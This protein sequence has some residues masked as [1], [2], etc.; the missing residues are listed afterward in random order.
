MANEMTYDLLRLVQQQ[1]A[2]FTHLDVDVIALLDII[3]KSTHEVEQHARALQSNA[4]ISALG[5]LDARVMGID[6]RAQ[7]TKHIVAL[8]VDIA[9]VSLHIAGRVAQSVQP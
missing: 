3:R 5:S 6:E 7:I 4:L 8:C 2:R 9:A 1:R